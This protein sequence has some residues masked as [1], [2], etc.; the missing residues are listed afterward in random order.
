VY[1]KTIASYATQIKVINDFKN[2]E[3]AYFNDTSPRMQELIKK[4]DVFTLE[5]ME[6]LKKA[7]VSNFL[8]I[9]SG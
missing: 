9:P 2:T 7:N 5:K 6:I 1:A 4:M 3:L 8:I